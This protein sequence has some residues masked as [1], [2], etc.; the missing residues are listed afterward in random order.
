MCKLLSSA[1]Q[2]TVQNGDE[3][4]RQLGQFSAEGLFGLE[5]LVHGRPQTRVAGVSFDVGHGLGR[6]QAN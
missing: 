2:P 4:G 1:I 5:I 3:S 6:K